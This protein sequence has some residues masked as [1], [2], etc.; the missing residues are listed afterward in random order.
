MSGS[1]HSNSRDSCKA[2]SC[3]GC[4]HLLHLDN[5]QVVLVTRN[6][7]NI[8][9]FEGRKLSY[10]AKPPSRCFLELLVSCLEKDS[11]VCQLNGILQQLLG[12]FIGDWQNI[13]PKMEIRFYFMK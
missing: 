9:F 5:H 2:F 3:L 11:F 6:S 7:I 8:I 12:Q 13:S 1:C 10:I 4:K